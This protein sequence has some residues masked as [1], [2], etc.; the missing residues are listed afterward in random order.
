M[1]VIGGIGPLARQKITAA[2]AGSLLIISYIG[3]PYEIQSLRRVGAFWSGIGYMTDR[4]ITK[5]VDGM[6]ASDGAGV[7]LLR[8]IGSP[9]LDFVDP[10]LMLDEFK[11]EDPDAYVGGFPDHPH[12][13][14]ETVSY[15]KKGKM[16][17][18]DSAGNEGLIS[19]GGVQWMTAGRGVIHS[20]MPE[21]TDGLLWGYQLWVNLPAAQKMVPPRYQDMTP[22]SIPTITDD[23]RSV[24]IIAGTWDG[25]AGGCETSWPVD[26]FDVQLAPGATFAHQIPDGH[27]LVMFGY[28]GEFSI[29]DA[30]V[31]ARQLGLCDQQGDLNLRAGSSGAGLL[32][33]AGKPIGEPVAKMGPFVMNTREELMQAADDF[34]AGRFAR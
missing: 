16:R 14:F 24:T 27:N 18:R 29:G 4:K 25:H 6:P 11:N 22:E 34:R 23:G 1:V 33:L 8:V 31:S 7:S 30:V 20:E 15:M 2:M 32:V 21:Q 9:M 5:I 28:E 13:G 19:D 26:I 3:I 17:H 10:F 12:R